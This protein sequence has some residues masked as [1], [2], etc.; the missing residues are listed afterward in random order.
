MGFSLLG[1]L[2]F[3]GRLLHEK[4]FVCCGDEHRDGCLPH[5]G[6]QPSLHPTQE[7]LQGL[8]L[9]PKLPCG[10]SSTR[11]GGAQSPRSTGITP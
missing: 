7:L 4:G 3:L 9:L 5:Q 6:F 10:W 8:D 1:A 2:S 11:A